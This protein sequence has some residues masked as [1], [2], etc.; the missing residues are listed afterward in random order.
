LIDVLAGLGPP[1]SRPAC[2]DL[3]RLGSFGFCHLLFFCAPLSV[4]GGKDGHIFLLVTARLLL[5]HLSAFSDG[6][7]PSQL[8]MAVLVALFFFVFLNQEDIVP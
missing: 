6:K 3:R 2:V 4:G 1:L 8:S 5:A 7:C